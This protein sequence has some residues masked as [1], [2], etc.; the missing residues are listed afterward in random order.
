[1]QS[2][3]TVCL[4]PACIKTAE[5]NAAQSNEVMKTAGYHGFQLDMLY[6]GSFSGVYMQYTVLPDTGALL[7]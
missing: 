3:S 5:I 6:R 2:V 7:D 4:D 1:M